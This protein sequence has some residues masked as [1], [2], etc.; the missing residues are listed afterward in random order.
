MRVKATPDQ[1]VEKAGNYSIYIIFPCT[2][3]KDEGG[4]RVY[5][6]QAISEDAAIERACALLDEQDGGARA[7]KVTTGERR[8]QRRSPD[9]SRQ[10]PYRMVAVQSRRR[11]TGLPWLSC[12]V[13][14]PWRSPSASSRASRSIVSR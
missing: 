8:T 7:V 14:R 9:R 4:M 10:S 12:R 6:G 5:V 13:L 3:G 11:V 2:P 1:Q